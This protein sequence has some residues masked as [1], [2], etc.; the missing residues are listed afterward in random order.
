MKR[1]VTLLFCAIGMLYS[2]P[3]IA[4]ALDSLKGP[5]EKLIDQQI[6][7]P[8]PQP[9][10]KSEKVS[11]VGVADSG[12]CKKIRYKWSPDCKLLERLRSENYFKVPYK[13]VS[14]DLLLEHIKDNKPALIAE[15]ARI[16]YGRDLQ[17]Y[18]NGQQSIL[19]NEAVYLH[20]LEQLVDIPKP[21]E[22]LNHLVEISMTLNQVPA[23]AVLYQLFVNFK[24]IIV[25]IQ[26]YRTA[27]GIFTNERA[28]LEGYFRGRCGGQISGSCK[29]DTSYTK[30]NVWPEFIRV[31]GL[32]GI[33][34]SK[35]IPPDRLGD[36][37]ENA[38]SAYRLVAYADSN[39]IRYVE[40]EA[41][42]R[43]AQPQGSKGKDDIH[44]IDFRNFTYEIGKSWCADVL[45]KTVV[46][47]RNG[48]S[49]STNKEHPL[50][51]FSL[52]IDASRIFYGDLTGDERDE[53]VV[54]T[55]CG[56][57]HPE[58]QAFIYTLQNGRAVLLTKLEEG[59]RAFGG[60][61]FGY[62]CQGCTDGIKIQNNLLTVERMLGDG[63]CCPKYIEKKEY[64]WNGR[65][66]IQVGNAQRRKF[67]GR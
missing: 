67:I 50:D 35:H 36:W 60:I 32:E 19:P 62:L 20:A 42:A 24:T 7:Q 9:A 30:E 21:L 33:S 54:L 15:L 26:I 49:E 25:G 55:Y 52:G 63:A 18:L 1:F 22:Y 4:G 8:P 31:F 43:S 57:M 11:S 14:D 46:Q 47:V 64:R 44:R 66:L 53:A 61:V 40:G 51:G 58:E 3:G 5:A 6:R 39:S 10:I 41:I 2:W 59:N 27:V 45:G 34:E 28:M 29:T 56:G 48:E 37:F 65:Q 13:S 17:R 16:D 23:S 38:F 12:K